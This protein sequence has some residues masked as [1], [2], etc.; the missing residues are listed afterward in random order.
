MSWHALSCMC[1]TCGIPE[2]L[3]V[4]ISAP[5]SS[6]ATSASLTHLWLPR[7]SPSR[8]TWLE[9]PR[10]WLQPAVLWQHRS[11]NPRFFHKHRILQLS[12][13]TGFGHAEEVNYILRYAVHA[14]GWRAPWTGVGVCTASSGSGR[15][16]GQRSHGLQPDIVLAV[17]A[18]AAM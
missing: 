15:P 7:C 3:P 2:T 6:T 18:S 12:I 4:R 11:D 1:T 17:D 13:W 14:C 16:G 5:P 8:S 9:H 10:F